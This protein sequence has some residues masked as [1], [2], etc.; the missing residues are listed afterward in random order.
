[1]HEP[2]TNLSL[3]P[4]MV[5]W[6]ST[7]NEPKNAAHNTANHAK[8]AEAIAV[9]RVVGG[10]IGIGVVVRISRIIAR[11]GIVVEEGA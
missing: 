6:S 5:S 9:R 11:I 1:M 7:K 2:D 10:V 8:N 3:L 4:V